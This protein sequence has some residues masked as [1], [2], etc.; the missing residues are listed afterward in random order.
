MLRA[1]AIESKEKQSRTEREREAVE[2]FILRPMVQEEIAGWYERELKTAFLPQEIKPLQDILALRAQNRYQLLGLFEGDILVGYAALW[3]GERVPV[4]LLDYLG[5]TESRR[6]EGLGGRVLNLLA[7]YSQGAALLV[8]SEAPVEGD[9]PAEN[10]IRLRRIGFYK[11]N[12]FVPAYEMATCGMRWQ[13]MI[14]GTQPQEMERIMA[15]HRALYGPERTDV[16][17]P[18]P[19]DEVPTL[20]YWMKKR[21]VTRKNESGR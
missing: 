17:I 7:E 15:G 18:L 13:T 21:S 11:R 8:E 4:V 2:K 20:P 1:K 14:W 5:V 6:N 12:G 10:E 9:D 3:T 16:K 19:S